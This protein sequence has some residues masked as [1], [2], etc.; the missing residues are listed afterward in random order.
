MTVPLLSAYQDWYCPQC[1]K[2]DRTPAQTWV[3]GERASRFHTCPKLRFLSAPM[4]PATLKA[5]VEV[6]EREDYINGDLVQLDP[7][8][9]RPIMNMV[10]TRDN[11]TDAR[12]FA[13][14]A[15]A[16]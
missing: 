16:K 7:E 13:P 14:T 2:T 8:R 12:V 6:R 11:G 3:H 1:K 5:K 10:T 9:G 15:I 4:L